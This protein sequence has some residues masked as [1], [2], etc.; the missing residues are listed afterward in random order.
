MQRAYGEQPQRAHNKQKRHDLRRVGLTYALDGS[1]GLP[2]YHHLYPGNI[3]YSAALPVALARIGRMPDTAGIGRETVTLMLD[4]GSAAL[5][6]TLELQANG[7]GWV[8]T[9]PW[10]QGPPEPR[11]LP[12]SELSAAGPEQPAV[13]AAA[14]T[15]HVHGEEYLCVLQHSTAFAVEQLHSTTAALTKATQRLRRLPSRRHATPNAALT[16]SGVV[17]S[18]RIA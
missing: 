16:D 14:R 10:H 12:D 8:S 17:T 18:M 11:T 1:S 13:R 7:P 2:L 3:S 6:N 4:K 9:L 15:D 5:A